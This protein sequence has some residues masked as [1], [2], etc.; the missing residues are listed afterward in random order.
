VLLTFR[1]SNFRSIRD[2]QVFSFLHGSS[3]PP[4]SRPSALRTSEDS[5]AGTSEEIYEGGK[6]PAW[7]NNVGTIAGIFG[8]NASGKSNVLKAISFM[9]RAVGNSYRS[10]VPKESIPREPFL[11][12]PTYADEPSLF[13]AVFISH[14]TRYQYGFRLTS[15][16]VVGEWLYAYPTSRRQVWF[17]RDISADPV[18]YFG[19]SFT[20]RNRV[21]ADLTA[22]TS[23]FLSTAVANN[24]K[25]AGLVEH[26]FRSHFRSASPDD[27]TMRIRYTQNLSK[28]KDRWNEVTELMKF[29]DLGICEARIRQEPMAGA[30]KDRLARIF[31]ALDDEGGRGP[32][33]SDIDKLIEEN[34]NV[35]EFAHSTASK[36]QIY[37]PLVSE[38]LGTQT[39]FS[40]VGPILDAIRYG[41]TL[42]IDELDASL[43]PHLTAEIISLFR[44][45]E[46]NPKQAQLLFT[47]HDTTLLGSLLGERELAREQIWFTEKSSDGATVLY[48]LTDF[49][50]RKSENLERGY[51]QGR[52]GAVPYLD[53]RIVGEI[54]SQISLNSQTRT[55]NDGI[56]SSQD[57]EELES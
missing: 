47:T 2:E 15:N 44:D 39:W 28:R 45:P 10:W 26:W 56:R 7:E 37:F 30:E 32:G 51:L 34:A 52:Y 29:A 13:E 17:E 21:I 48:P 49:S 43:H 27:R 41:N 42:T 35:V 40:L 20:G 4:P 24:H 16:Q 53:G 57:N 19:K 31:R 18:Y 11:L 3:T 33:S 1:V 12:E 46:K 36:E 14:G 55:E 6:V 50:P 38:S 9:D 22:P 54:A 23:L 8:A 25:M 5:D